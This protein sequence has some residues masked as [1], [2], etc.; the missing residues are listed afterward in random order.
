MMK[1]ALT[2]IFNSNPSVSAEWF[3]IALSV[4]A[5]RV[6]DQLCSVLEERAPNHGLKKE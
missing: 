3:N 1:S 6:N 5:V 2:R 4:P